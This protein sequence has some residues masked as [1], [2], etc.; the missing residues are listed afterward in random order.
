MTKS[1]RKTLIYILVLIPVCL[2][3]VALR[4][5]ALITQLDVG[6]VY[7]ND[8]TLITVADAIAVAFTVFSLSYIFAAEKDMSLSPSFDTAE[9][10]VP[11]G[12][13]AVAL[14]FMSIDMLSIIAGEYGTVFTSEVFRAP[15]TLLA[16]LCAVL[17]PLCIIN[18]FLNGF[19]ERKSST[20]RASFCMICTVFLSSYAAYLYFSPIFP[21]NAPC[22]S[23]DQMASLALAIFLL[24]ET[25]ISL[26]RTMWKP[27]IAFG[28]IASFLAA[29]SSIPSLIYYVVNGSSPSE[30]VVHNVLMLTFAIFATARILLTVKLSPTA[31]NSTAEA[32][33][34]MARQREKQILDSENERTSARDN[35]NV[36]NR[37]SNTGDNYEFELF[38]NETITSEDDSDKAKDADDEENTGH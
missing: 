27:Y 29:Y 30:S 11:S 2:I 24:Y 3:C 14:A 35:I 17:S 8:K 6:S 7:L 22:K 5:A 32:I 20:A 31:L 1:A 23:T 10:Y 16:L 12:L 37:K 15:H 25:R 21:M 18:F 13:V 4:S 19:V 9:T 38:T 34:A 36:E 33:I 26:G 28:L